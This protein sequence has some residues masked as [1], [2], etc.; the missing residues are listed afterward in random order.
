MIEAVCV[1]LPIVTTRVSGV[2]EL[3]HEGE[4]GYVVPCGDIDQMAESLDSLLD[5]ESL[6]QQFGQN[7]R[8]MREQFRIENIAAQWMQIIE[9][10]VK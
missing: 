2:K 3:V 8:K 4:N 5:N 6:L 9:N 1:G 7:S 10:I